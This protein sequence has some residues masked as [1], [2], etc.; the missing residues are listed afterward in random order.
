[1]IFIKWRL[2]CCNE[3]FF[4]KEI[5]EQLDIAIDDTERMKYMIR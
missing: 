2:C 3:K 4:D 5:L 1:M